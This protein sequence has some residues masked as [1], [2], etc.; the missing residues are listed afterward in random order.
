MAR[1][2]EQASVDK[3]LSG[4][5]R[6]RCPRR[7]RNLH[8][9]EVESSMIQISG[10]SKVR[11]HLQASVLSASKPQGMILLVDNLLFRAAA[12]PTSKSR[13][14]LS[15]SDV[16]C[17]GKYLHRI[18][19]VSNAN[20]VNLHPAKRHFRGQAD[21]LPVGCFSQ[22]CS[23]QPREPSV[24]LMKGACQIDTFRGWLNM[25]ATRATRR[26]PVTTRQ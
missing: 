9:R 20:R 10:N 17:E 25:S 14:G 26:A 24:E 8:S 1:S 19:A 7:S 3:S 12:G 18:A 4:S 11:S 23:H 13:N 2:R 21:A 22:H 16:P 6:N 15:S 5:L